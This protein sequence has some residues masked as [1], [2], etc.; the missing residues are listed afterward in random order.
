MLHS[1]KS[2]NKLPSDRTIEDSMQEA[3][4]QIQEKDS[5]YNY[6]IFSNIINTNDND[7]KTIFFIEDINF[8]NLSQKIPSFTLTPSQINYIHF[9]IDNE[10]IQLIERINFNSMLESLKVTTT[11]TINTNADNTITNANTTINVSNSNTTIINSSI[12]DISNKSERTFEKP[13]DTS[14]NENMWTVKVLSIFLELLLDSKNF[15]AEQ[16]LAA[17]K[18][19][20]NAIKKNDVKG[21]PGHKV[22]FNAAWQDYWKKEK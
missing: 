14:I 12:N 17:S 1:Q 2:N 15:R 22:D 3:I 10:I 7:I 20:I 6:E 18:A 21:R 19:H 16:H 4:I 9:L 11:E 8:L 5:Y 13:F